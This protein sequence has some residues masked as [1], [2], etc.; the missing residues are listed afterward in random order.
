MT[1]FT[2]EGVGADLALLDDELDAHQFLAPLTP[3]PEPGAELGAQLVEFARVSGK[4]WMAS[5]GIYGCE[6]VNRSLPLLQ[7]VHLI[8]GD[9]SQ[10]MDIYQGCYHRGVGA[11]AGRGGPV[12][13]SLG[14]AAPVR[15]AV[16]RCRCRA[17]AGS[18]RASA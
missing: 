1:D 6:C 10:S 9:I 18:W 2:F 7:M 5:F 14:P 13:L 15:R 12:P 4:I 17:T 3:G 16:P 8:R 11:S